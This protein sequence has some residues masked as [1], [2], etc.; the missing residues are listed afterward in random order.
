MIHADQTDPHVTDPS[1][2]PE[3]CR[4][5]AEILRADWDKTHKAAAM[6]HATPLAPDTCL[7]C[8]ARREI[9]RVYNETQR[10]DELVAEQAWARYL[11]TPRQRY[12]L[13][14]AVDEAARRDMKDAGPDLWELRDRLVEAGFHYEENK[15]VESDGYPD[16]DIADE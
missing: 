16:V 2:M 15:N 10:E 14:H 3:G 1:L 13:L 9:E 4:T 8:L 5:P 7:G 6:C 12:L 11:F